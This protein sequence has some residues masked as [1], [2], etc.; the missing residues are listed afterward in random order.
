MALVVIALLGVPGLARALAEQFDN[1]ALQADKVS[2]QPDANGRWQT[3]WTGHAVMTAD[4]P[5]S[6]KPANHYEV[7][8]NRITLSGSGATVLAA[9]AEGDVRLTSRT[10]V[11]AVRDAPAGERV[12]V[13]TGQ[14][15]SFDARTKK[16]DVTGSPR[17][18]LSDPQLVRPAILSGAALIHVDLSSQSFDIT[19]AAPQQVTASIELAPTPGS[20]PAPRSTPPPARTGAGQ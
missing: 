20:T 13:V 10:P 1:F 9:T 4:V 8:A 16:V 3:L 12:L 15:A 18:E 14:R 19:G 2:G 7:H 17:M 6:G 5:V 11:P